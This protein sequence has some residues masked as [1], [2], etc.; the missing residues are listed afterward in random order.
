MRRDLASRLQAD[1]I[2]VFWT[3]L[4]GCELHLPDHQ[5]PGDE[6]RWVTASA[7][8]VLDDDRIMKAHSVAKRCCPGPVTEHD[9]EWGCRAADR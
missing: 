7:S 5:H 4:V 1:D 3:V 6:Y 8:Y 9:V 2:T